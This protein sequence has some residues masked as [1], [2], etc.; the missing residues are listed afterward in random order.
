MGAGRTGQRQFALKGFRPITDGVDTSGVAG[1]KDPSDPFPTPKHLLTVKDDF[2]S[3]SALSAK[4][5]D[6]ENGIVTKIQDTSGV[7]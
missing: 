7:V 5:F 2:E 3:W 6:E 4:F 1:A